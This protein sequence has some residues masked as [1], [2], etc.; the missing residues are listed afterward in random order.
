MKTNI[1]I[2]KSTINTIGRCHYRYNERIKDYTYN[3]INPSELK[4]DFYP[5]LKADFFKRISLQLVRNKIDNKLIN[6]LL[7]ILQDNLEHLQERKN[8][9][10]V[11]YL[12]DKENNK[13]STDAEA[14]HDNINI[15]IEVQQRILTNLH[16]YLVE[17][18]GDLEYLIEEDF[19]N[20]STDTEDSSLDESINLKT[21]EKTTVNLSKKDSI[22]L[23]LLLEQLNILDFKKTNRNSFIE[24]NFEYT[25]RNN[26]HPL[27]KI[28]S[29]ISNL[30]DSNSYKSRN[31]NSIQKLIN[32]LINDLEGFDFD[33]FFKQ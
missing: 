12:L 19:K 11:G 32:K 3:G 30:K 2:I 15:I 5:N 29:D 28:N 7:K 27:K 31:K 26:I 20:L 17:L 6:L 25:N 24:S 10:R 16:G 18:A 14:T 23:F 4:E 9:L 8:F 33:L 1:A 22:T 21:L 13:L